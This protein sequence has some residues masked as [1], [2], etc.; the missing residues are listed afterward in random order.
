[1]TKET[2]DHA[3]GILCQI[4]IL[5]KRFAALQ[6]SEYVHKHIQIT[7]GNCTSIESYYQLFA[8]LSDDDSRFA[9][10]YLAINQ[11]YIDNIKYLYQRE[12]TALE[13]EFDS[14]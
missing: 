13:A 4:D 10:R 12:L 7:D 2:L 1:M 5:R 3:K 14:L 6:N 11:S 8:K 9:K